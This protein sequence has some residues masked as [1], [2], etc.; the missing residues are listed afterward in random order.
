MFIYVTMF[1]QMESLIQEKLELQ[2]HISVLDEQ[3]VRAR[4]NLFSLL[5]SKS[6]VAGLTQVALQLLPV[7]IIKVRLKEN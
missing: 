2:Q 3:D 5:L 7:S 6:K 4:R 1:F